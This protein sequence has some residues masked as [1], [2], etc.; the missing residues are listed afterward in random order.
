MSNGL[1]GATTSR[2]RRLGDDKREEE[3]EDE[4]EEE[5]K[6]G[7]VEGDE[8]DSGARRPNKRRRRMVKTSESGSLATSSLVSSA[9]VKG[10]NLGKKNSIGVEGYQT[11]SVANFEAGDGNTFLV[12]RMS[13]G[14]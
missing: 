14:P 9:D 4:D 12:G 10:I 1:G 6:G 5:Q 11:A 8:P 2:K 7:Q 3:V 13:R